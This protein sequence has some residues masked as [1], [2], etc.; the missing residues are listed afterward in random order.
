M[1][2]SL[3]GLLIEGVDA[4]PI[5]YVLPWGMGSLPCQLDRLRSLEARGA[6]DLEVV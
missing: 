3:P 2:G 6:R 4:F 5:I 1:T